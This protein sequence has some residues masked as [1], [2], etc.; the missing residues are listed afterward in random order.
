MF[1]LTMMKCY[2]SNTI[3]YHSDHD[4]ISYDDI[5]LHDMVV[6]QS[7]VPFNT[8][9]RVCTMATMDCNTSQVNTCMKVMN[10]NVLLRLV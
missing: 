6:I 10:Y 8:M 7:R 9:M 2:L 4:N 1:Y 5:S 3:M